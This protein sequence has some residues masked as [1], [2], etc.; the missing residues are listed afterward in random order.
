MYL[1]DA[2][3]TR[4]Q[5]AIRFG[6]RAHAQDMWGEYP[7]ATHLALVAVEARRIEEENPSLEVAA[8]LHDV[9]EDHPEYIEELRNDFPEVFEIVSI[10]S[11]QE[12]EDYDDFI[13]RILESHNLT[14]IELKLA[15]MRV[16]L[17]NGPRESLRKRYEKNIDRLERA[18]MN[19]TQEW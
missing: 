17:S 9:I 6:C 5:N 4:L 14:A 7:Y 12:D 3:A 11:R 18:V 8:W 13:T 15:D 1:Y 19:M 16:N 10:V 2:D